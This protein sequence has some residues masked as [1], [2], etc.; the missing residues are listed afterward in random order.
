MVLLHLP[1]GV[2]VAIWFIEL[3][4][5]YRGDLRKN[6]ALIILHALLFFGTLLSLF[7]GLAY[8]IYGGYG[9]EIDS[10]KYWGYGFA[11]AVSVT[12]VLYL[13][14]RISER[15]VPRFVY[16]LGLL[17]C[18]ITMVVTGHIGGELIH[19]KGF[20]TKGFE[21][22]PVRVTQAES[23]TA[24]V[25]S[26]PPQAAPTTEISKQVIQTEAPTNA[27]TTSSE[28]TSEPSM[29]ME[30][31]MDATTD[32]PMADMMMAPTMDAAPPPPRPADP[33]LAS[34]E[35]AHAVFQAHCFNCHGATKQKGKYRMDNAVAIM[36]AGKSKLAP[37]VPGKLED[38]ELI[39]RIRLPRHD[40]DVMPP[41]EKAAVPAEGITA[42]EAW[43]AAG[44]Y[45][46]Q[47]SERTKYAETYVE[48]NDTTTEALIEQISATGVKAEY[49]AWNDLRV[50]IDLGV[51]D[52]GQLEAAVQQLKAF[53]DKLIWIDASKLELP[54]SFYHQLSHFKNLERLHL[55]GSNV[56]DANLASI[57]QLPKLSYLNLY[58][59]QVS[60]AGLKH[61]QDKANLERIFLTNTQTSKAGIEALQSAQSDL[62]IIYR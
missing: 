35:K 36:T 39:H 15:L 33:R 56:S 26:R 57:A 54:D 31:M 62:E 51:V 7:L 47:A 50:R 46:P 40:D 52:P 60:D 8:A 18:T 27:V 3:L 24:R 59:S 22:E 2:L 9:D 49:N 55:D 21:P 43:V 41:E 42:I 30:A 12:F 10:H 44:A 48:L 34:F 19:G 37:I 25:A 29:E 53:G 58:N 1:I 38:S 13:L 14:R 17:A 45:W 61:L 16:Y 11:A 28:P 4:P 20:L 32:E 5:P 23:P 6:Q